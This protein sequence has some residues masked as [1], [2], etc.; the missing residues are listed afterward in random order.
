MDGASPGNMSKVRL[1]FNKRA[2]GIRLQSDLSPVR[3]GPPFQSFNKQRAPPA[4]WQTTETQPASLKQEEKAWAGDLTLTGPAGRLE[5]G[6][7]DR[8]EPWAVAATDC[9]CNTVPMACGSRA[10]RAE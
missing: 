6:A 7:Q 1:M 9:P 2:G 10:G 5:N 3:R 8:K 4:R